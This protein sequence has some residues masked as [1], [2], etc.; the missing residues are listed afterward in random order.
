MGGG[1]WV[2]L[3]GEL[4]QFDICS[5][6]LYVYDSP[7]RL[8]RS[9]QKQLCNGCLLSIDGNYLSDAQRRGESD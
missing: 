2:W 5:R 4:A 7:I 6:V 3:G 9:P 8:S 1:G